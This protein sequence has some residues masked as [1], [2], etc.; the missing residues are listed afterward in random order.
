MKDKKVT[1]AK[2]FLAIKNKN[3]NLMFV[4]MH[5]E[6]TKEPASDAKVLYGE[7]GPHAVLLKNDDHAIVLDFLGPKTLDMMKDAGRAL[8]T[9]IRYDES[10]IKYNLGREFSKEEIYQ[11]FEA[12]EAHHALKACYEVNLE[13][14]EDFDDRFLT[15]IDK[16]LES[17]DDLEILEEM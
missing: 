16:E 13:K 9:E 4:I 15:F 3:G 10:L 1:L 6:S 8:V 12:A 2:D 17:S 7:N 14:V 11:L 5:D